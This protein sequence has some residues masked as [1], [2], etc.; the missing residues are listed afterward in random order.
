MIDPKQN[1]PKLLEPKHTNQGK[2]DGYTS[3]QKEP[4]SCLI[5]GDNHLAHRCIITRQI[6]DREINPPSNLCLKHCGKKTEACKDGNTE[7]CYIFRKQN[8]TLKDITCGQSDHG[9]RHFLL[10]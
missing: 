7:K 2:R 6:R 8:G 4:L 3:K 10:C 5:C 9:L 1:I